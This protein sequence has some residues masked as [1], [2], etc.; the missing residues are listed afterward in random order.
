[1]SATR[2]QVRVGLVR[3]ELARLRAEIDDWLARRR[4]LDSFLQYSTQLDT[5][6]TLLHKLLKAIEEALGGLH[7]TDGVREV[8][9]TCHDVAAK[10]TWTRQV[11]RYFADKFDQRDDPA[12][13][14]ALAAADEAVWSC[15]AGVYRIIRGTR[16]PA[17]PLPFMEPLYSPNAIPRDQPYVLRNRVISAPFLQEFLAELPLPVIGLPEQCARAPWWLIYIGHEVGHHLQHDLL[18]A[19]GLVAGFRT[20]LRSAALTAA[21]AASANLSTVPATLA[22]KWGSWG[23]EVF[24]DAVSVYSLGPRAVWALAELLLGDEKTMLAELD[25]YPSAVVRLALMAQL[26]AA[27]DQGG[28]LALDDVNTA[29]LTA[30]SPLPAQSGGGN[31]RVAARDHLA[32][33]PHLASAIDAYDCGGLGQFRILCKW[34]ETYFGPG[35]EAD[36]WRDRLLSGNPLSFQ[37]GLDAPRLIL[38]GGLAAWSMLG[39]LSDPTGR[40]DAEKKLAER[41]IDAMVGSRQEGKRSAESAPDP[42]DLAKR[43]AAF[44]MELVAKRSEELGL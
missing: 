15:F 12:L 35:G 6:D 9:Q 3:S 32:L 11:W 44:A 7:P 24:A 22:D 10:L 34:Q 30:G 29:S 16:R 5:L 21:S 39:G 4:D 25:S 36:K 33:V 27:T 14:R 31:L 13:K 18:P 41:L 1:V 8:Y 20:Y 2:T 23:E 26:P 17:A 43:S 38:G 28:P 40:A 37:P 42:A 19:A